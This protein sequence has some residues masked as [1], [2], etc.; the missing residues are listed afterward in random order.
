MGYVKGDQD[1]NK[2]HIF[3]FF[4]NCQPTHFVNFLY[5]KVYFI[6]QLSLI[7]KLFLNSPFLITILISI[8]NKQMLSNFFIND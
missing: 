5:R 2:V 3:Y 6:L 8:K 1:W 4:F 7:Q